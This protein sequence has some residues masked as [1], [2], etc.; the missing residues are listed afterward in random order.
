MRAEPV[1]TGAVMR[2][3]HRR[4]RAIRARAVRHMTASAHV[5]RPKPMSSLTRD[6]P[7]ASSGNGPMSD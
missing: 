4:G 6:R 1:R 5:S 2:A 7:A 3:A